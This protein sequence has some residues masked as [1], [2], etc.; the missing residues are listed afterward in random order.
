MDFEFSRRVLNSTEI[1][2]FFRSR[3][4]GLPEGHVSI[5]V[6]FEKGHWYVF[7]R[8]VIDGDFARPVKVSG[9]LSESHAEHVA[10]RLTE[11]RERQ[12][13]AK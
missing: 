7:Y 1:Q 9:P 6:M 2:K 3:N 12:A 8:Q 11:R 4:K 13:K 5:F 10:R